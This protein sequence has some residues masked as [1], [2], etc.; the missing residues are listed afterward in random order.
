ME[1]ISGRISQA[2]LIYFN[3]ADG[4]RYE[5]YWKDGKQHGKGRFYLKDGTYR[6]N[7][8]EEGKKVKS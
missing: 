8:W 1:Y 4:R 2:M 6:D 7:V 3:R 5:G